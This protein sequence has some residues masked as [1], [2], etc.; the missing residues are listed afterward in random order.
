MHSLHGGV[1]STVQSSRPFFDRAGIAA[2]LS[3]EN[4][5]GGGGLQS[6]SQSINDTL[7]HN[8]RPREIK[9][10]GIVYL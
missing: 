6:Q 5:V 8:L 4:D 1:L 7:T 3:S 2:A 9:A 10:P